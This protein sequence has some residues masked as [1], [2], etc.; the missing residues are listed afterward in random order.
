MA[1]QK[2]KCLW[3]KIKDSKE[4]LFTIG[5]WDTGQL[6]EQWYVLQVYIYK[7]SM[8]K[9]YWLGEYHLKYMIQE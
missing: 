3:N 9:D 5:E 4:K 7:T 6:L 1:K 8:G 2:F